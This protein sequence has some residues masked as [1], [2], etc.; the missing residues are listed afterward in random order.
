MLKDPEKAQEMIAEFGDFKVPC[1]ST[2]AST[3][4]KPRHRCG[5]ASDR[6]LAYETAPKFSKSW[7]T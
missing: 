2:A 6:E 4:T 1:S 5:H 3:A 7:R